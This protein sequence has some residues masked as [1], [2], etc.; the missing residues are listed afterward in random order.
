MSILKN[1]RSISKYEYEN[2]FDI[3]YKE[4]GKSMQSVPVR[5]RIWINTPLNHRL[6]EIYSTIMEL[7]TN[8]F[9]NKTKNEKQLELVNSIINQI[10]E[11]Q[12]CLYNFWN[13]MNCKD[14][15][16][17]SWCELLNKELA[18]LHGM[19]K[20]NPL[21]K[22]NKEMEGRKIIYYQK[23]EIQKAQFLKNMS[24]FHDYTH[25][26]ISHAKRLY[27]DRECTMISEYVDN[28]W[29]YCLKANQ[30]I[31]ETKSEYECRKK[32]ISN[33]IS[34]IIKMEKPLFSLFNLMGYSEDILK[35][36]S[37]LMSDELRLLRALRKS[38]KERF[39]DLK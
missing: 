33:A 11:L 19:N 4:I 28:A 17:A 18:L 6:N 2:T 21:Y 25:R 34:N 30:K 32:C 24:R 1:K 23:H 29:Y 12:Q 15:K 14:K 38:D 35:E 22:E 16:K 13:V 3:I 27:I 5:L 36:W 9:P 26:K 7:R 37:G 20:K 39:S 31:P 10:L 8:Y